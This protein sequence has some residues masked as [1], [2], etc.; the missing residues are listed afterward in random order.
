MFKIIDDVMKTKSGKSLNRS[1][2]SDEFNLYMI[3][4][5]LSMHSDVNVEILNMTVNI[6]YKALDDEQHF[7]F[8]S[9]I[10][11]VTQTRGKYIKVA[12]KEPKKKNKDDVDISAYFE[13]SS[14]KI[15]ESLAFVLG[16]NDKK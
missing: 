7:K 4:R 6:L 13:E 10:L 3:Q 1:D 11:P 8:M 16:D 9:E 15:D 5:W 12:T 2:F 14:S